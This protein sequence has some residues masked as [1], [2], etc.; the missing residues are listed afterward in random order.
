MEYMKYKSY[1][2]LYTFCR[3]SQYN[4]EIAIEYE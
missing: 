2:T 4:V 1:L 3:L